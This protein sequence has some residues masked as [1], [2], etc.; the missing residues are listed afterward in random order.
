MDRQVDGFAIFHLYVCA[1]FLKFWSKQICCTHDFTDLLT[2]LQN[3]PTSDWTD[4]D[5]G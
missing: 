1:A 3:L 5:I 4:K 2:L